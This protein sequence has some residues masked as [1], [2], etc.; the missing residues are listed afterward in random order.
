MV[1]GRPFDNLRN[2]QNSNIVSNMVREHPERYHVVYASIEPVSTVIGIVRHHLVIMKLVPS[3]VDLP[4]KLT[5]LLQGCALTEIHK[6]VG[7]DAW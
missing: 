6:I 3:G 1:V 4:K 5:E 7:G 2:I